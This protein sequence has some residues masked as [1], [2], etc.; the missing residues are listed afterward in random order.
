MSD[1]DEVKKRL[2][3]VDFVSSFVVL[4]K[5]GRN[6]KAH[7]PFHQEKTP[8]FIVSPDRQSWHCFGA[9]QEGGDAIKFLMK[10]ENIT[11]FEALK[12]LAEQ[13]GVKLK[14][15]DFEDQTWKRKER[16]FTIN[17]LA[18][19]FFHFI[20]KK[21]K[22]GQ[23]AAKYL[24]KR[25]VTKKMIDTFKLGYAPA[26]WN[27]LFKFLKNRGY[28]ETELLEAGLVIKSDR[29]SLYDRFRKRI[30]F[31]LKDPR[32]NTIGFSGRLL[33]DE[34]EAKYVNTPETPIYHKRETLFGLHFTKDAIKK[35]E[36]AILVEG[37]FDMLSLF[38]EG[39]SNVVAVKGS[40]VTRYQLMLLKRYA[41]KLVLALDADSSGAETTKKIIQ[42]T[43]T[44][45]FNL[46][47]AFY[48]FAKDPDEAIQ[49]DPISFKRAIEKPIPIYDFI[50]HQAVKH[51]PESDA[52]SKKS[53][54]A[55]VVPF[56]LMIQNPIVK[57][58]YIAR[59]ANILEV[60]THSVEALL[61]Q[62]QNKRKSKAHQLPETTKNSELSRFELLQKYTL[63]LLVQN[64]NPQKIFA[65]IDEII[66][67]NDF[68]VLS[69]RKLLE[70]FVKIAENKN[71][72]HKND[73]IKSFTTS[74]PQELVRIVD[75][76]FLFDV[77]L[78]D[79]NL[80]ESELSKIL[81]ELKKLSLKNRI[82][83]TMHLAEE[84]KINDSDLKEL[85][86]TL[87]QVEKKLIIL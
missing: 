81:Y 29:G 37:E 73:W 32:G 45:D 79:E 78:F 68:S 10:L 27:A 85:L 74:L 50:I 62:E 42:D 26:S 49:K 1:V 55:E 14:K 87:S 34:K 21:H 53:L 6:F 40:A 61:R 80:K 64:D 48:D 2:D 11:F 18:E 13:T 25:G 52:F 67:I 47:V 16:L 54:A 36:S 84:K 77:A 46:S 33:G 4:K 59:L 20:L 75:E 83:E 35:S 12:E 24:E 41:K 82:K 15:L 69:Y 56:F 43:E 8:S 17:T 58:H 72:F 9:C 76:L 7:C 66:D 28:G 3:I 23:T 63:S 39:I 44:M 22:L 71:I 30:M 51:Y 57:S 31:P 86:K 38:K 5:A 19:E 70:Q 65:K 60:D